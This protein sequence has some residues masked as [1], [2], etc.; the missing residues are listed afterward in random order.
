MEYTLHINQWSW[1]TTIV[2]I[3]EGAKAIAKVHFFTEDMQPV[4][5]I[6][7][8][9]VLPEYRRQGLATE[10]LK[11]CE[12]LCRE[13]GEKN[14]YLDSEPYCRSL[15]EKIGYQVVSEDDELIH[16]RKTI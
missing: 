13:R 1:G 15:Y 16:M 6:S 3:S 8:V 7:G 10:L 12:G 5:Y 9:S 2:V 4:C 11:Y 14:I